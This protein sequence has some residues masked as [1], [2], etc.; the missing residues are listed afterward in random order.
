MEY[1]IDRIRWSRG[2][3]ITFE[4]NFY[5][6][7]EGISCI[8]FSYFSPNNS[9]VLTYGRQIRNDHHKSQKG[10]EPLEQRK[11]SPFPEI[12]K[13]PGW[14]PGHSTQRNFF[15]FPGNIILYLF[16]AS[17]VKLLAPQIIVNIFKS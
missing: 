2:K 13:G 15:Q 7:I 8:F 4:L 11:S 16:G 17:N 3:F 6:V 5:S 1:V 9:S 12:P 14:P 10:A